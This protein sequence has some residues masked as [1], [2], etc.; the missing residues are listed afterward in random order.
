MF[1]SY[2]GLTKPG[3]IYGNIITCIAGFLLASKWNV[4]IYLLPETVVGLSLVIA[5]GCVFNNYIDR[6][7]DKKMERTKRRAIVT[8]EISGRN[9]LV[10]A[11]I[12]GIAGL[13]VLL[14]T[15][16]LTTLI[17]FVGFFFYVVMYSMAKRG[18]QY[19]VLVG[20]ISGAVPPVVGY[21]AVANRF[22][23]G[24]L[25]LFAILTVWQM[26]HFYAISIYKMQEYKAAGIPV[27]PLMK[28]IFQT[29][30]QMLIYIILFI[31]S[32]LLLFALGYTGK[33]YLVIVLIL[34]ISW[35][36]FSLRGFKTVNNNKWARKMF[37][38]S[39]VN[40]LVLCIMISIDVV[41]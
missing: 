39:L 8:G 14:L 38:F 26:P 2:Y 11:S 16:L 22:D 6:K 27:L 3:I 30:L 5:S 17:A 4:N 36:L 25:L 40:L 15:N 23:I 10:F 34:G 41:R 28:G 35:L 20:S 19:G 18:S 21:V 32:C 33:L 9:A 24:A 13:L 7:I 29:K 31:V 37:V 12:L 1:K